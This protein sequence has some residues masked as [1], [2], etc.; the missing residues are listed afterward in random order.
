MINQDKLKL[1]LR[2][3]SMDITKLQIKVMLTYTSKEQISCKLSASPASRLQNQNGN[4]SIS[5][6]RITTFT[7]FQ[8]I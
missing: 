5:L 8:S 3:S 6:A 4:A 2:R 7:K 1:M